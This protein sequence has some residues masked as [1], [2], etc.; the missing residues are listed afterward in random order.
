MQ[1]LLKMRDELR[2]VDAVFAALQQ[3]IHALKGCFAQLQTV[4]NLVL[5]WTQIYLPA[6]TGSVCAGEK[7]LQIDHDFLLTFAICSNVV[8][9]RHTVSACTGNSHVADAQGI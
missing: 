3:H 8:L 9:N 2:H 5:E 1:P 6:H 7:M 4:I